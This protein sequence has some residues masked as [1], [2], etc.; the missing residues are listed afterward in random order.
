MKQYDG[1]SEESFLRLNCSIFASAFVY[2]YDTNIWGNRNVH[3]PPLDKNGNP[4]PVTKLLDGEDCSTEFLEMLSTAY[5]RIVDYVS[6]YATEDAKH[7]NSSH[8]S[9]SESD[10]VSLDMLQPH[11]SHYVKLA[12]HQRNKWIETDVEILKSRS[13]IYK[14]E[15]IG[16]IR[17][18]MQENTTADYFE[19]HNIQPRTISGLSQKNKDELCEIL[20][21]L[22]MGEW[23]PH[24]FR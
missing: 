1:Q 9:E 3:L 14:S 18:Y 8:R 13:F 22:S 11:A 5:D 6:L 19:I 2:L 24:A 4:I 7:L 12:A 20:S 15:I 10:G 23:I 21:G 17:N 16:E